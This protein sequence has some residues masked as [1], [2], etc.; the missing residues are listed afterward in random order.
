M[1]PRPATSLGDSVGRSLQ[2]ALCSHRRSAFYCPRCTSDLLQQRRTML[3]ALQADVAVLRKK[4]EF[5]LNTKSA[6][7]DAEQRLDT[8]RKKVE[9]LADAVMKTRERLCNERITAVEETSKLEA[10][11]AGLERGQQLLQRELQQ[12]SGFHAPLL[13][14]LDFQVQWAIENAAKARGKKIREL[15]AFFGL[16]PEADAAGEPPGE[17]E[18]E[19]PRAPPARVFFRTITSLPLPVS[20]RF[21]V[22]PPEVVAAALG[23]VIHLLLCVA[24]YLKLT[25]PHPMVFNGSF[26]TIGNTSEGAGCHTL[27]PDGSLGFDR[28]V[29]MVHENIAFLWGSQGGSG[30]GDASG[31][32]L[33][34][35][36]ILGNLLAVSRSP[37]LGTL[38][39]SPPEDSEK[40]RNSHDL[41]GQSAIFVEN[42]QSLDASVEIL[43]HYS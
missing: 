28:G 38:C 6:L 29:A 39:E 43:P 2:C 8:S 19:S 9:V 11:S 14:C 21:E 15:F 5:A 16:A 20:G 4:T 23:K 17:S 35:T 18:S 34:P 3:A 22:M 32:R 37:Q 41:I 24:K 25:Y 42:S 30:G 12:S 7:V 33:H 36:D 31:T 27:Y 13:E 10:Q 26:S 1:T 40:L